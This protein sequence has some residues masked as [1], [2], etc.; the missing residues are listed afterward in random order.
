MARVLV[1]EDDELLRR[2]YKRLLE[3]H[4]HTVFCAW[5]AT[6]AIS[7]IDLLHPDFVILDLELGRG[8]VLGGRQVAEHMP[9]GFP[10]AVVTGHL[11]EDVQPQLTRNVFASA[12]WFT[13]SEKD[14]E[15]LLAA[16]D[17]MPRKRE[18][19]PP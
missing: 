4:G 2:M 5:T 19:D 12:I 15:H 16:I 11:L 17:G 18:S 6:G 9:E 10:F 8:H 7:Q 14:F 1:V 13:K 3:E